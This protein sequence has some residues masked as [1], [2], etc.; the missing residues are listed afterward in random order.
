MGNDDEAQRLAQAIKA[1]ERENLILHGRIEQLYQRIQLLEGPLH[2]IIGERLRTIGNRIT[3]GGLRSLGR[4]LVGT[5]P[6]SSASR[7]APGQT[8]EL[9]DQFPDQ[10]TPEARHIY[11]CL[12]NLVRRNRLETHEDSH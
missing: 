7:P 2:R 5:V 6:N 4:R 12:A 11:C 3:G 1:L 10:L 9:P 8:K